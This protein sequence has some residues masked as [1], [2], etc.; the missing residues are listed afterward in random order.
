V[1]PPQEC[2]LHARKSL[3]RGTVVGRAEL[4][5]FALN[6]GNSIRN[7]VPVPGMLSTEIVPP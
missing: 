2:G 1:E 3:E 6:L 5:H 4:R 7:V